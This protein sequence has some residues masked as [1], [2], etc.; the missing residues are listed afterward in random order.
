MHEVFV[1]KI[2]F[3]DLRDGRSDASE[4][5]RRWEAVA[6]THDHVKSVDLKC[7]KLVTERP[8]QH[9]ATS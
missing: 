9:K 3:V 7:N 5:S 4:T 1:K 6:G 2:A 8:R